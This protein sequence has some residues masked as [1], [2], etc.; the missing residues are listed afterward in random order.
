MTRRIA[1]ITIVGAALMLAAP[2]FGKG[3]LESEP[4]SVWEQALL[5]KSK[6]IDQHYRG[7]EQGAS[8][9][10]GGEGQTATTSVWEQALIARSQGLNAKYGLGEHSPALEAI[11]IRSEALN[12]QYGLGRYATVVPPARL[13]ESISSREAMARAMVMA[14]RR[15]GMFREAGLADANT[16]AELRRASQAAVT[17][18]PDA[19]ERTVIAST[20]DPNPV[21]VEVTSGRDIEWPQVGI[22]VG[23]GLLL[24]LFLFVALRFVRIRPLAH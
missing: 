10:S 15:Y 18:G 4:P 2:A 20:R 14:E 7:G 22:G 6:G 13:T 17:S 1:F 23:F 5:A 24:G 12:K 11:R 9:R 8:S 3:Q 21:T 16:R 19:F